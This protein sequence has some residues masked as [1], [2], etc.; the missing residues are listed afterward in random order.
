MFGLASHIGTQLELPSVGVAKTLF[1]VDGIEYNEEHHQKVHSFTNSS[2]LILFTEHLDS[3]VTDKISF[4][5][6]SEAKELF[7][8][9]WL[10]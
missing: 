2:F 6:L 4:N 5:S 9:I 8:T 1:H 7:A 10:L 3:E